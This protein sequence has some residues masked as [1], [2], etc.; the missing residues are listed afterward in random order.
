MAAVAVQIEAGLSLQWRAVL[1]VVLACRCCFDPAE[2]MHEQTAVKVRCAVPGSCV[3]ATVLPRLRTAAQFR[4]T[5]A[6]ED[7]DAY[8]RDDS[9][10]MVPR[11][12]CGKR[13]H[14]GICTAY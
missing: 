5:E 2:A 12:A 1:G 7:C 13:M 9:S 6:P 3:G 14:G 11:L 8:T 10:R 4:T